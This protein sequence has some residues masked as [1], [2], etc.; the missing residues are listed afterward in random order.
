MSRK[1]RAKLIFESS[2]NADY[3]DP[4]IDEEMLLEYEPDHIYYFRF[5][6]TTSGS[7]VNGTGDWLAGTDSYLIVLKNLDDTNFVD[8][9][10]GATRAGRVLAGEFFVG[11][12][13]A[14]GSDFT[15]TADTADV[16]C[17]LFVAAKET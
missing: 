17:E 14:V 11:T 9:D 6:A 12:A 13:Q 2:A 8:F 1:L 3:S 7:T 4:S 5:T 15:V 10:Q 16:E